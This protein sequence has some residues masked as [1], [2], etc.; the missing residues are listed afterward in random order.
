MDH[1]VSGANLL[2]AVVS[3]VQSLNEINYCS[4]VN[5]KEKFSNPELNLRVTNP[6]LF[7]NLFY[8]H[9][10]HFIYLFLIN[11]FLWILRWRSIWWHLVPFF[12][13]DHILFNVLC[14]HH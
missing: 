11:R 2:V 10:L 6:I 14:I 12:I 4:F 13:E 5:I 9:F 1:T 8:K 7:E 3:F